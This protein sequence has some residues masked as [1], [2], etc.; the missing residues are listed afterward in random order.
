[1][2]PRRRARGFAYVEVMIAALVVVV[3]AVPAA[4]AI[5]NGVT[6]SQ[7]GPARSAELL[8]VRNLMETVLA[9][10][11]FNL[12]TAAELA[13]SSGA[14]SYSRPADG[15]CGVRTVTITLH[16]FNGSALTKLVSTDDEQRKTAL[17]KVKVALQNS[18]YSFTT[19]VAR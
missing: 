11:Y 19:V 10:P 8:C 6:A 7:A 16:Q 9:E 5:R 18:D 1:M 3:C 4:N 14:T 12:N 17:L 2:T 15:V 13:D